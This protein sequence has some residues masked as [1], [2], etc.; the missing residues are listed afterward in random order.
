[1][2]VKRYLYLNN[3]IISIKIQILYFY[4]LYYIL[5]IANRFVAGFVCY[6]FFTVM[7]G[8]K[9]LFLFDKP[10]AITK[11]NIIYNFQFRL[12]VVVVGS[13]LH[14]SLRYILWHVDTLYGTTSR[15]RYIT[16]LSQDRYCRYTVRINI[17]RP[18][19]PAKLLKTT[20]K[21]T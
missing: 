5:I 16:Q 12:T 20:Y 6:D 3:R 8:F 10:W 13:L 17:T 1:M 19:R 18:M 7:S 14:S 15:K 4:W 21:W 9:I 11:K 2:V